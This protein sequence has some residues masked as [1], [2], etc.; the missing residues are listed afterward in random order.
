MSPSRTKMVDALAPCLSTLKLKGMIWLAV[1]CMGTGVRGAESRGARVEPTTVS[2]TARVGRDYA[3][4]F[5]TGQY[6]DP[7][8]KPLVNPVN[9]AWTLARELSSAFG[10]QTEIVTNATY[11]TVMKTFA[12]YREKSYQEDDQLLVFFAG[13]GDFEEAKR[14]GFLVTKDSRRDD[15]WRQ[16]YIDHSELRDE[17]VSI[18]CK[19]ILLIMDVCFGGT[20]DRRIT[21]SPFRGND[22]YREANPAELISRKLKQ[23]SRL[24]LTSGGK[25]YVP[26]G[27]P[28]QHSPFTRKLLE[29]LGS[30]GGKLGVL[31]MQ[32][33]RAVLE[34]VIPEP[35]AGD[36]EGHSPGGDFLFISTGVVGP[37][38]AF[39]SQPA[40]SVSVPGNAAK[41]PSAPR[42]LT[43]LSLD[44][45]TEIL[46]L[47][48]G[49]TMEDAKRVFGVPHSEQEVTA[50]QE[51][52]WFYRAG[53]QR[54][55]VKFDSQTR[56]IRS[57]GL[58]EGNL[59]WLAGRNV[60]DPKLAVLGKSLEEI[61]SMIG[62]P[63]YLD[64][65]MANYQGK[66]LD[67]MFYCAEYNRYKCSA[68]EIFWK[69]AKK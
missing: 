44:D 28:G 8:W 50:N 47:K 2:Q 46:G 69:R 48:M 29:A 53:P 45:F 54:F 57:I 65:A 61:K 34:P 19:H 67:V 10:F 37:N 5:A 6:D 14:R 55:T 42:P 26:D 33:V 23:Q 63:T 12:R 13:H 24:Y 18:K 30:R 51:L 35:R 32:Q 16:S 59:A 20:F 1:L 52:M 4:L 7:T 40:E 21:E 68:L 60:N 17:I 36:F 43:K 66:D 3:L 25:E 49:D 11:D 9:D 39:S 38:P 22:E 15:R 27:R 31:T 56:V 64:G 58:D 41:L 62:S